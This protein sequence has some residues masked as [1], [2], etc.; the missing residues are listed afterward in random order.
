MMGGKKKIE[1]VS[2]WNDYSKNKS[3]ILKYDAIDKARG[4]EVCE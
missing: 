3:E 1:S 2:L 4:R